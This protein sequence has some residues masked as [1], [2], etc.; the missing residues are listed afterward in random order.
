[1]KKIIALLVSLTLLC[2]PLAAL[3]GEKKLI[4]IVEHIKL[5]DKN[6]KQ[7]GLV[8][9]EKNGKVHKV[10]VTDTQNMDKI[11]DHRISEGDTVRIK[12]E[13]DNSTVTY[14]RKT[15]GC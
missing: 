3:A 8:V 1:M 14:L 13:E 15:A 2:T 6:A 5:T 7:A 11:K 9:K 12:Y 4:G 10:T